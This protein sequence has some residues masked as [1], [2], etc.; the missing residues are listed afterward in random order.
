MRTTAAKVTM[1]LA[2][3]ASVMA[4]TAPPG[5]AQD[6]DIELFPNIAGGVDA[7]PGEFPFM[8][9]LF[10]QGDPSYFICGGS[11]ID[12]RWVLTAAHCVY[13]PEPLDVVI[14][15]IDYSDVGEEIEVKRIVIH[16]RYDDPTL[17]NDI[18]LLELE[19][20]AVT[21][22]IG[23]PGEANG[24]LTVAGQSVTAIGLGIINPAEDFPERLQVADMPIIDDDVCDAEAADFVED[25]MVCARAPGAATTCPGDSGSPVFARASDATPIQ[26]GIT[27]WGLASEPCATGGH[28]GMAE[29]SAFTDWIAQTVGYAPNAPESTE[30]AAGPEV[31]ISVSC[32][33]GNG[34]VDFNLVNVHDDVTVYRV[35]FEG[36]SA[37]ELTIGPLDW[38][39]Q[40]FTGRQDGRYDVTVKRDG[41]LAID[42][43]VSVECDS[44]PS[45][46]GDEVQIVN[47]CRL[48]N[49]YILAQAVNDSDASKPYV[50]AFDGVPNRST[51]AAA[52]GAAVRAIT[53]RPDG[54]YTLRVTSNNQPV[55]E[56]SITVDCD[57][58][59]VAP[60]NCA[61]WT[62]PSQAQRLAKRRGRIINGGASGWNIRRG[63]SIAQSC[64]TGANSFN[65]NTVDVY[66]FAEGSG[67][68]Q[69]DWLY[70]Y[71]RSR[72]EWG[73]ISDNAV[74]LSAPT[75]VD[76][77]IWTEP[78][79]T[80]LIPRQDGTVVGALA[81]GW[82][83]RHGPSVQRVCDTGVNGFDGDRVHVY[84]RA[85][86]SGGDGNDWYYIYNRTR[87][88]WGWISVSA[89]DTD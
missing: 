58:D 24:A 33:A 14:G 1:V 34:R 64:D 76:C 60:V 13:P 9:A 67:G 86:A 62:E 28:S 46:T 78:T 49:G 5:A 52:H 19:T 77:S 40:S 11:L 17:E 47:S 43:Q 70:I 85:P 42:T 35:E 55:S 37:R 21:A 73:W 61:A 48:G 59:T 18:A 57:T 26:V 74:D 36:L 3:L 63:P 75:A 80:Q 66:G 7:E 23:L 30:P 50:F 41:V 6:D 69:I 53:G 89:V 84:A 54:E 32:L 56:H 8:V 71:N 10:T 87:D 82:N 4:I 31:A 51:S 88:A 44:D 12:A 79:A 45:T 29:V 2:I 81:T 38:G 83:Q 39:R 68:E 22:P 16:P 20:P 72:D 25:V 65:G 27:S 15:A